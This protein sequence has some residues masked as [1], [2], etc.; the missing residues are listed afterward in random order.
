[1]KHTYRMPGNDYWAA[2]TNVPCPVCQ[3]G[4]VRRA[5]YGNVPGWRQCDGCG[6]EYQAGDHIHPT[7]VRQPQSADAKR[8]W[9]AVCAYVD[10]HPPV[11]I[12]D[13]YQDG[14]HHGHLAPVYLEAIMAAA[15]ATGVL[16]LPSQ[17][18]AILRIK[19]YSLW[20]HYIAT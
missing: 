3:T 15:D 13:G 12:D 5:E 8:Q 1:M 9:D 11:V 19:L 14:A 17:V 7:L 2:V 16:T 6:L 4:T 18:Q 10:A 20:Q